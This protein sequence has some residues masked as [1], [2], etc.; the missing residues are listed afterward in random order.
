MW[1]SDACAL[2][3]PP[4]PS[5]PP[6]FP[7]PPYSPL[8][9]IVPLPS[10]ALTVNACCHSGIRSNPDCDVEGTPSL[11]PRYWDRQCRSPAEQT[12][13]ILDS[14]AIRCCKHDGSCGGSICPTSKF[15]LRTVTNDSGATL[16]EAVREC[17]SVHDFAFFGPKNDSSHSRVHTAHR[18]RISKLLL[19]RCR[20]FAELCTRAPES[21][22]AARGL[23][24]LVR[25]A[26]GRVGVVRARHLALRDSV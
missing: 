4:P 10:S 22:R 18:V 6:S 2:P 20:E 1:S 14:P 21:T 25:H 3:P 26:R 9:P 11:S 16:L 7:P 8:P 17:A 15:P 13:S 19:S 5:S 23:S 24:A 12:A